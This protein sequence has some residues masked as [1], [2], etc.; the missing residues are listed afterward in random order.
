MIRGSNGEI[1]LASTERP[2]AIARM[3]ARYKRAQRGET[4]WAPYPIDGSEG[5]R[6]FVVDEVARDE[7][8]VAI[9][10]GKGPSL[11]RFKRDEDDATPVFAVNE[12][13]LLVNADVVIVQDSAW[14][15]DGRQHVA[16]IVERLRGIRASG[17]EVA[18]LV[19]FD[20]VPAFERA[21]FDPT[22]ERCFF[23]TLGDVGGR[24]LNTTATLLR[25]LAARG[26]GTVRAIGLDAMLDR[27]SSAATGYARG[28]EIVAPRRPE[29][30]DW[31][32]Q[33]EDFDRAVQE[34][35]LRVEPIRAAE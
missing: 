7:K 18:L 30:D 35:G 33:R 4:V 17:R 27:T 15:H 32:R 34:T 22:K 29:G 1:I 25:L 8:N 3:D 19:R 9:V 31:T 5:P 2:D 11:E 12:A 6:A 26:V 20:L 24:A 13:C 14:V 23:Y 16:R 21:G 10:C 28:L